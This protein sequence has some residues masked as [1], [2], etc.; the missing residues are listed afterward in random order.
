MRWGKITL[1]ISILLLVLLTVFTTSILCLDQYVKKIPKKIREKTPKYPIDVVCVRWLSC[2]GPGDS[3][4]LEVVLRN[5][6]YSLIHSIVAEL[7]LPSGFSSV[8]GND[9]AISYYSVP[10]SLG[11]I[12]SLKFNI[13]VGSGVK[14][15]TYYGTLVL[16]CYTRTGESTHVLG[17]AIPLYG[18]AIVD[19]I[20]ATEEITPYRVENVTLIVRNVGTAP[21][22]G[23]EVTVSSS[24]GGSCIGCTEF[25]IG[26]LEPGEEKV[27]RVPVVAMGQERRGTLCLNL[28]IRYRDVLGNLMT[29][30]RVV[31]ISVKPIHY[32]SPL[33]IS[34]NA[35]RLYMGKENAVVLTVENIGSRLLK[36]VQVTISATSPLQ[37]LTKQVHIFDN[38]RGGE[39][40]RI[41][42]K[43]YVPSTGVQVGYLHVTVRYLDEE[44]GIVGTHSESIAFIL[45]GLVEFKVV[46]IV[47]MPEVVSVGKP[48][49]VTITLVNVGTTTATA[50]YIIPVE[51]EYVRP[52]TRS[53]FI[54]NVQV[55]TPTTFTISFMIEKMPRGG[56]AT[57]PLVVTY[58]DNLRMEH[59]TTITIPIKV[60]IAPQHTQHSV[61]KEARSSPTPQTPLMVGVSIVVAVVLLAL[62]YL[63]LLRRR[64]K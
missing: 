18:R 34:V 62:L 8:D 6:G 33:R 44:L 56:V 19:V 17:V 15:G 10:I 41:L 13:L 51:T 48:G 28:L 47:Q 25:A 16:K 20:S 40:R 36:C 7:R 54:G 45:V 42:V 63:L 9:T 53:T 21:A 3:G 52:L 26:I 59:N 24:V 35:T 31:A 49:S 58:M 30:S 60:S 64:R 4:V 43:I 50:T 23:V 14:P 29:S 22:Y 32:T 5:V 61:G 12:F 57:L 38:L 1:V 55:N 46:D 27:V 11:S 37:L 2:V 39:C